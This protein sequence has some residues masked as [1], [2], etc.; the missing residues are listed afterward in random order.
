[1]RK[2][3]S[4][5][6]YL[7]AVFYSYGQQ[8]VRGRILDAAGRPIPYA[9]IFFA[10]SNNGT[11][12]DSEGAF[13]LPFGDESHDSLC[14]MH[15]D[16]KNVKIPVSSMDS[17]N[18][19]VLQ[20]QMYELNEVTIY[21]QYSQ[22]N[23][24]QALVD[25]KAQAKPIL[26]FFTAEWCYFCRKYK[27][28]FSEENEVSDYLKMNYKLVYCDILT[29]SGLKLKRL[30]G[31]GAGLPQ[32]V[33]I[34]PDEK[35]VEKH[36][37]SWQTTGECLDFLKTHHSSVDSV[38]F[39]KPIKT[40]NYDFSNEKV[41]SR[42]IPNFD[43][44]MK[45][46]D[47]RIL[48]QLGILNF[49][50]FH[51][52]NDFEKNKIG[53]EFGAWLYYQKE[54]KRFSYQTGLIFSSQGGKHD[55]T[56]DNFRLNYLEMPVCISYL[57]KFGSV[58]LKFSLAAYIACGLTAKDKHSDSR[59]GFGASSDQLKR[60][61]YGITPGL[62]FPLGDIELF[63]GY[64]IGL[65]NISNDSSVKYFNRGIYFRLTLQFFGKNL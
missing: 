12:S 43:Y 41:R 7:L 16:Y 27:K 5:I 64:K 40:R 3:L 38:S 57:Q 30:C 19:I 61:D 10:N 18:Q 28:L 1:M 34:T 21:A 14:I 32:F 60:W 65:Q 8:S 62:T 31:T 39:L 54:N 20:S 36:T 44:R 2:L 26:L 17:I 59:I 6:V 58:P 63:C 9:N 50:N 35:I 56:N 13:L 24:G 51:N 4:F 25:A 49:T 37:G 33:V 46:T 48:L 42:P 47:W 11:S 55:Q 23:Y 53:Y 45:E 29:E 52:G 22:F 15:L